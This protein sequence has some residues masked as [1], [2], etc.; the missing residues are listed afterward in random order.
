MTKVKEMWEALTAYQQ[1]ADAAGHGKSWARMCKEKTA[2]Y[3]SYY[4][5]D[6]AAYAAD[7]AD[8]A[9]DAAMAAAYATDAVNA[10]AYATDAAYAAHYAVAEKWA[11]RAIE[12][13]AGRRTRP[14]QNRRWRELSRLI[15]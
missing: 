12:R 14:H 9:A 4:A 15:S 7:A 6:A 1:Q 13:I 5:A 2:Y 10:A 11:Q 8:Y 3:A